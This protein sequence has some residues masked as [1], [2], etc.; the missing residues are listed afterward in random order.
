MMCP[1]TPAPMLSRS[2]HFSWQAQPYLGLIL[3]LPHR[4]TT[5]LLGRSWSLKGPLAQEALAILLVGP[6]LQV[7]CLSYPKLVHAKCWD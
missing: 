3:S 2:C 4:A 1:Y 5:R 7:L 6:A